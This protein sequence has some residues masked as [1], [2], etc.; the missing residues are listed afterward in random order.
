MESGGK[1]VLPRE[2]FCVLC[3][4]FSD[5]LEYFFGAD[6]LVLGVLEVLVEARVEE[7]LLVLLLLCWLLLLL[8]VWLLLLSPIPTFPQ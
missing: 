6:A 3:G 2:A 1:F 7:A 4:N 5:F 8:L